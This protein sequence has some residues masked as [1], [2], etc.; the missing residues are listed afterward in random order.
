MAMWKMLVDAQVRKEKHAIYRAQAGRRKLKVIINEIDLRLYKRTLDR[1][2]K[3]VSYLIYIERDRAATRIQAQIYRYRA[4]L[5]FI[6][7]H[8]SKPIGGPL[9]DIYLEPIRKNVKFM[10]YPRVR[11]EKRQFWAG[12]LAIQTRYRMVCVRNHFVIM[13]ASSVMI[14]SI[15]RMWVER[16]EYARL[17]RHAILIESMARMVVKKWKYRRLLKSA[18][19]A[20]RIFR[21][22]R[23][24]LRFII[25]LKKYRVE[26]ERRL[27]MPPRIQRAWRIKVAKRRVQAL[28][29]DQQELYDAAVRLQCFWYKHQGEFPRF[30]L[31]GVLRETDKLEQEF[32]KQIKRYGKE[33]LARKIQRYYRG[34]LRMRHEK[35]AV[36]IQ[37]MARNAAG[38]NLVARLR[39][40]KWAN[41]KLRCWARVMMKKR[42][43][44]S[45]KI[46]FAFWR[47]KK[48]RF[49]DHLKVMNDRMEKEERRI[50][51]KKLNY[52][53][54]ILQAVVHGVWTRRII[55]RTVET[56]KIQ[57]VGRGF[58]GR[59]KALARLRSIQSAV[60]TSFISRMAHEA[61]I[62]E[63]YRIKKVKKQ[64]ATDIERCWRGHA[65]R[66][67]LWREK[68][69]RRIRDEA[70]TVL[71]RKYRKMLQVKRARAKILHMK[72]ALT[73]PFR[74]YTSICDLVKECISRTDLKFNPHKVICGASLQTLCYR[75]HILD[76]V[77]PLLEKAHI[78]TTHQLLQMTDTE[79]ENIGIKEEIHGKR[80]TGIKNADHLRSVLVA[81]GKDPHGELS[82]FERKCHDDYNLCPSGGKHKSQAVRKVFE[83]I[84]GDRFA[85]RAANFAVGA[86]LEKPLSALKLARFFSLYDTP[87]LAKEHVEDL[88]KHDIK[89]YEVEFDD[90]RVEEALDSMLYAAE[91]TKLLVKGHPGLYYKVVQNLD[92]V[93][94]DMLRKKQELKNHPSALQIRNQ[95]KRERL[96]VERLYQLLEDIRELDE[97]ARVF[98]RAARGFNAGRIMKLARE[99]KFVESVKEDYLF[100]RNNNHVLDIWKE[101]R[102]KEKEEYDRKYQEWLKE[103]ERKRIEFALKD[104]LR[105][106][107]R[108]EWRENEQEN[109]AGEGYTM[110]VKEEKKRISRRQREEQGLPQDQTHITEI[111]EKI[112]KPIYAYEDWMA[113]LVMQRLARIYMAKTMVKR[114]KR[115]RLRKE[116]EEQEKKK[117]EELQKQRKQLV[118]LKFKL[119]VVKVEDDIWENFDPSC[120]RLAEDTWDSTVDEETD[121]NSDEESDTDVPTVGGSSAGMSKKKT[122]HAHFKPK[123]FYDDPNEETKDAFL[124][125]MESLVDTETAIEIGS[126]VQ[127][128]FN[129]G[130][131]YY[132]GVVFQV[133]PTTFIS[134][135][136]TKTYPK[137]TFG[138]LYDDGD[139]EPDVHKSDIRVVKLKE[140]MKVEARFGGHEAYFPGT[141]TG[142]NTRDGKILS[143]HV[144]YDDGSEEKAV[145]RSRI[146]VGEDIIKEIDTKLANL[147]R[148]HKALSKRK[149]ETRDKQM[150][151]WF[152]R[153]DMVDNLLEEYEELSEVSVYDRDKDDQIKHVTEI[154]IEDWT[155]QDY[156]K[157]TK[158]PDFGFI[159]KSDCADLTKTKL[160][161]AKFKELGKKLFDLVRPQVRCTSTL[162]YTKMPLPYGWREFRHFGN[163]AGYE[164]AIT[165]ERRGIA[166]IPTFTFQE[167]LA[168]RR[169]Q[170]QWRALEGKREFQKKLTN[171]SIL[172]VLNLSVEEAKKNC[173]LGYNQEGMTL[174]MWLTRL[175]L[176][177]MVH[178]CME[179][180]SKDVRKK[181]GGRRTSSADG[182]G[183]SHDRRMSRF[184]ATDEIRRLSQ[185]MVAS[186][187][188]GKEVSEVGSAMVGA[189]KASVMGGS[190]GRQSVM[191]GSRGRQS[192]VGGGSR[193]RQSMMGSRGR[194]S[195][196]GSRGR[197]GSVM[198]PSHGRRTTSASPDG[199][200]RTSS[201]GGARRRTNSQG[202][203][204]GSRRGSR[205]G[206]VDDHH[207]AE[208]DGVDDS[209]LTLK[210]FLRRCESDRW[211]ENI[212]FT[213]EADRRAIKDMKHG[214]LEAKQKFKFLN[215]Y[216]NSS[217]PR[218]IRHCVEDSE[219][220]MTALVTKRYKNNP[221]RVHAIVHE[222]CSSKFPI[223]GAQ[224]ERFFKKYDGKPA[225]AQE[226]VRKEL[227]DV[228]TT[229]GRAEEKECYEILKSGINRVGVLLNNLGVA[230]LTAALNEAVGAAEKVIQDGKAE[231]K[232]REEEKKRLEEEEEKEK[233]EKEEK[234]EKGRRESKMPGA[235]LPGA[236][237]RRSSEA[238]RRASVAA[239][240]LLGGEGAA[241]GHKQH[242][243]HPS[244][245][246]AK[247]GLI[248][249][250]DAIQLVIDWWNSTLLLQKR[251][252]GFKQRK[253]YRAMQ[254]DRARA[255]TKLQG[256]VRTFIFVKKLTKYLQSQYNSS[257][258]QLW[259]DEE[260]AFYWF[261]KRSQSS[262]WEEPKEPYRPMIRDKFTQQLMQAWPILDKAIVEDPEAPPGVCMICKE[263][264]ATRMC[265]FCEPKNS[266]IKWGD[267]YLHTCFVCFSTFHNDSAELR[268]HTFTVT[269]NAV[270]RSLMCCMCGDLANR[271]CRG[272]V[273]ADDVKDKLTTVVVEALDQG[274]G[275]KAKEKGVGVLDQ[276]EEEDFVEVVKENL[277]LGHLFSDERIK[278]MYS[279]CRG[280]FKDK[281]S[282]AEIWKRFQEH[283]NAI[284]DEC[285]ENYCADCWESTHS[286]GKRSK[287]QWVGFMKGCRVCVEC[288]I[289][290]AEKFCE[291]CE[292]D[293]CGDCAK[294]THRH[295]KK[296]RHPFVNIVEPLEPQQ[297]HCNNCEFRVATE[298][299][300]FCKKMMC[301]S[302]NK[303]EHPDSCS[304]RLKLL[305]GNKADMSHAIT[306]AVCEKPPDVM[307]EQCGDVYCS[308]KWMGNPGCFR[309]THMKGN[310][311]EHKLVPYTFLE[312]R[313]RH[314]EEEAEKARRAHEA[315]L[316]KMRIE[317]EKREALERNLIEKAEARKKKL[318]L[319]AQSEFETRHT[320][321]LQAAAAK[322]WSK[323]LPALFGGGKKNME[324]MI[325][326]MPTVDHMN[327]QMRQ[328]K[329]E[330]DKA[331]L[332]R[333]QSGKV[334]QVNPHAPPIEN[335]LVRAKAEEEMR[336]KLKKE[337]ENK[338]RE[339][340]A[341]E[342]AKN[343]EGDGK[344][345]GAAVKAK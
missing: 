51:R 200:M 331:L 59:R 187:V 131:I 44:A 323:Y 183:H 130:E 17:R 241:G 37:C 86:V 151:K 320:G 155:P 42:N 34:H 232:R 65:V 22:Y 218:S 238:E 321:R 202:S 243:V 117:W 281:R 64:S 172:S 114:I 222:L 226:N 97:A 253:A 224:V 125:E 134:T 234:L 66:D 16:K 265:N 52:H 196:I 103:E 143:Y 60:A 111:L 314:E 269:K 324:N 87:G 251:F 199:G 127:A 122:D 201:A 154:F 237:N 48:G 292:D 12:A 220:V 20:Q 77:Y 45:R 249:R 279:E 229:S 101:D 178:E 91:T 204:G 244:G 215:Y 33:A 63:I 25:L 287:H 160:N 342:K 138:I 179:R 69:D 43:K 284:K 255:A 35:G 326:N 82:K 7:L 236:G 102:R 317:K 319:D 31:L 329:D 322:K 71:Q 291:V 58:L 107:W 221:K 210:I 18:G 271:R 250:R 239:A 264:E 194:Q 96:G 337:K 209:I 72:R 193:E 153:M 298:Q 21:G 74:E 157:N 216:K 105:E 315:R 217:D 123:Y 283:L 88:L 109:D 159:G 19:I 171:Q 275:G 207:V 225:M 32:E 297:V 27:S 214:G 289:L 112:D 336:Q 273:I 306:C 276:I 41:R 133:N 290:P 61:E 40:E 148:E 316:E 213:R 285:D 343:K 311:K 332:E 10:I 280:K 68:E 70:A 132:G 335:V 167:D 227:V 55:K 211:L 248:L 233:E 14:Q 338:A 267:G 47:G 301:D 340:A 274:G 299:C 8:D 230:E 293:Y 231:E 333:E 173:W 219:D 161:I 206:T 75:L 260:S 106:G 197:Q 67:R 184:G 5:K 23:A 263:E 135:Q 6:W 54:S 121:E 344:G 73:N 190:R 176:G 278:A 334:L 110:Y 53:A 85:A 228:K 136:G 147:Y 208:A 328:A 296:Y 168:C 142:T 140:G 307:C 98:Q 113:T 30:V 294:D 308:V 245:H 118:T 303:F 205:P 312:D 29:D 144:T 247:A 49:L 4:A 15:W 177:E 192:I 13:K 288:E 84:Y 76:D 166:D 62:K 174:E 327:E 212:G 198:S 254:A 339:K 78:H 186:G 185:M 9:S 325:M 302:C 313:R 258:E 257:I 95:H 128:K 126:V 104:I 252:R 270:A 286:R 318:A 170:S 108:E 223:T 203:D 164:N 272:M 268:K 92:L 345:G 24:K 139:W 242:V 115:E 124:V 309:K 145:R 165:G 163:I 26:I 158:G 195:V 304:V 56:M 116:K 191:G 169:L 305:G 156:V 11:T 93:E 80:A 181:G 81:L 137:D 1:W 90:L 189:R 89:H 50:R 36:R 99:K 175:G 261:D 39:L 3:T 79:L 262:V 188:D 310:R 119:D 149:K 180:Y 266:K 94:G 120:I 330:Y 246:E 235:K 152:D 100:Q 141:V 83:E 150:A 57:R 38:T 295:G 277:G 300:K 182:H 282:T 28:R 46:A 146:K 129:G 162:Q 256:G 341:K 259:S 240:G 2:S